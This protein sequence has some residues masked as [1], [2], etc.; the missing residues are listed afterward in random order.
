MP[1][2]GELTRDAQEF[3]VGGVGIRRRH[4]GHFDPLGPFY[5]E[6]R[7][8]EKQR[9]GKMALTADRRFRNR[10][11][12]GER[13]HTLRQL[14]RRHVIAI[15]VVDRARDGG[16]QPCGRKSRNLSDAGN[17]AGQ[18]RPI[19]GLADAKR[20]NDADAGDGDNRTAELVSRFC[21]HR[22]FL[23][24]TRSISASPSPRQLATAVTT[25]CDRS[26]GPAPASAGPP[27]GYS[28]PWSIAAQAIARLARNWAS[29]PWPI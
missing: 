12:A 21:G 18:F 16:P 29:T 25:T 3:G 11:F 23:Q 15:Y 14:G 5:F 4:F 9:S 8:R 6:R 26:G 13:R 20:G 19:G 27:A 7:R 17:A 10:L 1:A 22:S 24:S 28:L 2:R